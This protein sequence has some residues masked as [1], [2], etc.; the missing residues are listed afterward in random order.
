MQW[1]STH[2]CGQRRAGSLFVRLLT[3]HLDGLVFC[4]NLHRNDDILSSIALFGVQKP[5]PHCR[6]VHDSPESRAVLTRPGQPVS[7]GG[8]VGLLL[9]ALLVILLVI[10]PTDI[11]L[12]TL[13][14]LV[15]LGI[16]VTGACDAALYTVSR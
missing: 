9:V 1:R 16:R 3:L 8:L 2:T 6:P 13:V 10:L 4:P 11:F 5:I 7:L 14:F 12:F 15:L